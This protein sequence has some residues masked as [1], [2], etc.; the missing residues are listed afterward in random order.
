MHAA[1]VT[2][3]DEAASLRALAADCRRAGVERRVL[4]VRFSLVPTDYYRPHH[5]RL[6]ES[7][8]EGLAR[9]NRA[10][11]FRLPA[12]DLA[13]AWRGETAAEQETLA[14][15][16][17]L[18]AGATA[19]PPFEELVRRFALPGDGIALTACL[20][21]G[22]QLPV[23]PPPP[24]LPLDLQS[25]GHIEKVLAS[26]DVARFARRRRVFRKEEA[27]WRVAWERRFLSVAELAEELA[28]ERDLMA[29]PWLF[30]RLTRT[31]DRR[32]LALLAAPGELASA[33]RFAVDLNIESILSPAFL[34][35][36][37]ALQGDL[38]G[39]V[40]LGLQPAD[41]LADAAAFVFARDFAQGRG[42]RLVASGI[43]A[44]LLP[45]ISLAALGLDFLELEFSDALGNLPSE[46]LREAAGG[47][48]IV[49][50]RADSDVAV[51]W[52]EA[53]GVNL[54]DGR[55]AA[56]EFRRWSAIA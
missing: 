50:S 43:T 48:R 17:T 55:F 40:L 14:A 4:L 56:S 19:L 36:D 9:A 8:L 34:A 33:A 30:R 5:G 37:S 13:V 46:T 24:G 7:A 41:I 51:A 21:G 44:A 35:F 29:D 39:Q 42:Y 54:F 6:A 52:G 31:L 38:R 22:R 49:L 12:N 20:G 28:P 16:W 53:H 3:E 26:A 45:A 25:L 27:S 15:L 47:G 18:F 11:I 2:A 32:M 23:A 1:V 10:R